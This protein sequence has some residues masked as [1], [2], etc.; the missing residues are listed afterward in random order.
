MAFSF[1]PIHVF[2]PTT[3]LKTNNVVHRERVAKSNQVVDNSSICCTHIMHFLVV[4]SYLIFC[5]LQTKIERVVRRTFQSVVSYPC[6]LPFLYSANYLL[7]HHQTNIFSPHPNYRY[8]WI[9][10]IQ[11]LGSHEIKFDVKAPRAGRWVCS[12]GQAVQ[13]AFK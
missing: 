6:C 4:H 3:S 7:F 12:G 11:M 9:E 1:T 2:L 10:D 8:S 13:R 5:S